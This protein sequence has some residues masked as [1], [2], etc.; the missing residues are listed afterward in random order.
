MIKR[1]ISIRS[2]GI[3]SRIY[4]D[5]KG[6][7]VSCQNWK[8]QDG[9]VFFHI[10]VLLPT[11]IPI[12]VAVLYPPH[13]LSNFFRIFPLFHTTVLTFMYLIS[14]P[15]PS[16]HLIL[17][18]LHCELDTIVDLILATIFYHVFDQVDSLSAGDMSGECG[19]YGFFKVS[20]DITEEGYGHV[21]EIV[22]IVFQYIAMLKSGPLQSWVFD[23]CKL[24]NQM[25]FR[26]KD[27][28]PASSACSNLA[29]N[30]RLYPPENVISAVYELGTF[31]SG[32]KQS[33]F[34]ASL[35]MHPPSHIPHM[36]T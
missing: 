18:C 35:Q 15:I 11:V 8:P 24:L 14:F 30:L 27:K 3:F 22:F 29:K 7:E 12:F 34:S 4:W 10:F 2:P 25:A 20:L 23:E 32:K 31:D 28:T 16:V 33:Y 19:T 21:D 1:S 9:Y 5:M 6:K 36:H 13:L 17:F 26:F